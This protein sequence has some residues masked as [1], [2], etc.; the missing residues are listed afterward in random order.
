MD[1]TFNSETPSQ[2]GQDFFR[3]TSIFSSDFVQ[4][5]LQS[6]RGDQPNLREVSFQEAYEFCCVRSILYIECSAEKDQQV[7]A[8]FTELISAVFDHVKE[9]KKFVAQDEV[10]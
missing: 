5:S 4:S 6:E 10:Q 7:T 9:T 2:T 8:A 3:Q 1:S